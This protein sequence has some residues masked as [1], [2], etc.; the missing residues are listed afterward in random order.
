MIPTL[1][2]SKKTWDDMRTC[3]ATC[4]GDCADGSSGEHV[5][6][7]GVFTV[8]AVKVRGLSWCPDDFKSVGLASFVQNVLCKAHYRERPPIACSRICL[9]DRVGDIP[10]RAW[11]LSL[12][13]PPWSAVAASVCRQMQRFTSRSD[14]RATP[15]YRPQ[16]DHATGPLVSLHTGQVAPD[17]ARSS[18]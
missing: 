17:H 7:G 10:K 5:I 11:P 2:F 6:T 18:R 14:P 12:A 9:A 1:S 13:S 16:D 8:D 15:P 3:W 4:L